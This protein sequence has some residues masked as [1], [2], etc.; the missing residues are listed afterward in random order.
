M[1]LV[2]CGDMGLGALIWE[3]ESGRPLGT[4]TVNED[5]ERCDFSFD[6]EDEEW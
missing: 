4:S 6:D 2:A 5:R 3:M 1:C